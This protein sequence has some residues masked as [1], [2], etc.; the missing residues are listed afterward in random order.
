MICLPIMI[1]KIMNNEGQRLQHFANMGCRA[2]TE[3]Y[4]C[5]DKFKTYFCVGDGEVS[6][7]YGTVQQG[8]AV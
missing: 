3:A 4:A 7:Q 1:V 5:R 8:L 6:W 2:S